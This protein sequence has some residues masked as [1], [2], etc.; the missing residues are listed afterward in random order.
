MKRCYSL[1]NLGPSIYGGT[2]YRINSM[3]WLDKPTD[4]TLTTEE[5]NSYATFLQNEIRRVWST[6]NN[7]GLRNGLGLIIYN[8]SNDTLT[9][10][11]PT[12]VPVHDRD[13]GVK[14]GLWSERLK[15]NPDIKLLQ[16]EIL[17]NVDRNPIVGRRAFL[18][19]ATQTG[20][21][22]YYLDKPAPGNPV[23]VYPDF[24]EVH[25]VIAHEFGH[26]LGISDR[27]HFLGNG[28]QDSDNASTK[29]SENYICNNGLG[30][31][32]MYMP[33]LYDP[34]I[35][36]PP[37]FIESDPY[38]D[39]APYNQLPY[40]DPNRPS[41]TAPYSSMA[42]FSLVPGSNVPPPNYDSPNGSGPGVYD[43]DYSHGYAWVHNLFSGSP[44]NNP[45]GIYGSG[46]STHALATQTDPSS[47]LYKFLYQNEF[48]NP[49]EVVAITSVQLDVVTNADPNQQDGALPGEI[50]STLSEEEHA[51]ER[52][53][54]RRI[55]DQYMF[56]MFEGNRGSGC[57]DHDPVGDP[58]R[59]NIA[60]RRLGASDDFFVNRDVMSG[61]ITAV[62]ATF[63]GIVYHDDLDKDGNGGTVV[64][65]V[66][67]DKFLGA[68]KDNSL[69]GIGKLGIHD[70]MSYR[71]S[72][73][74]AIT[75]QVWSITDVV[76]PATPKILGF[77]NPNL[78]AK[79]NPTSKTLMQVLNEVTNT[80]PYDSAGIQASE[81][82]NYGSPI[83]PY[84]IAQMNRIEGGRAVRQALTDELKGYRNG[85]I[86]NLGESADLF[87]D[88]GIGTIR[89][90][91]IWNGDFPEPWN[92]P[93]NTFQ[94]APGITLTWNTKAASYR[95]LLLEA[96]FTVNVNNTG[97]LPKYQLYTPYYINR[98]IFLILVTPT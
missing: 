86:L 98:R 36:N 71:M 16:N 62:R 44:V 94:S 75:T 78:A 8:S 80:S 89:A 26:A 28:R 37:S 63:V 35:E 7:P 82:I 57:S 54:D 66:V 48:A 31:C 20:Q 11:E 49:T 97:I 50:I 91:K 53:F 95:R 42:P 52:G 74:A 14:V 10:D 12:G 43:M 60:I 45:F 33:G 19:R 3:I 59:R 55:F 27:Y 30:D 21:L 22:Y 76:S 9:C 5:L 88:V 23:G 32:P 25:N 81:I 34:L 4:G 83:P 6:N 73:F 84:F 24:Q 64:S 87:Q 68:L 56:I 40:T 77:F 92:L 58:N 65:D 79:R 2:E 47:L 72:D 39:Q 15:S 70:M 51:E 13:T 38:Y 17:F 18:N 1:T 90:R 61:Q 96:N 69:G 93:V 85:D 29:R 67:F 41:P 46:N